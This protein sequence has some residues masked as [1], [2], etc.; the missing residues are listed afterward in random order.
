M[1]AATPI[2]PSQIETDFKSQ[3]FL[4]KLAM[5]KYGNPCIFF[6]SLVLLLGLSSPVVAVDGVVLINQTKALNGNVTPGDTAGFPVTLSKAGS[7]TLAGNL[8]VPDVNTTAVKITVDNVSLDLNGFTISNAGPHTFAGTGAG[9]DGSTVLN[10]TVTNGSVRFMGRGGIFLG[11]LARVEKVQAIGNF[12]DG[13]FVGTNSIV[14]GNIANGNGDSG[15][16]AGDASIVSNN[17]VRFNGD[18]GIA[19]GRGSNIS[20]NIS[21]NGKES[22]FFVTCPGK[23]IGNTALDNTG[24]DISTINTGCIFN[25]NVYGTIK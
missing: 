5:N 8:T 21:S 24:F 18:V 11:H 10:V 14:S 7:Y 20:D 19:T 4:E 12:F 3:I 16:D 13:I 25:N 2:Y 1:R 9:V 15:I 22:G 23:V 17:T 6:I